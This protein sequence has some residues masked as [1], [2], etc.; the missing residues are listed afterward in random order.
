M[1]SSGGSVNQSLFSDQRAI[2][3]APHQRMI[4]YR[5]DLFLTEQDNKPN[6][7]SLLPIRQRDRINF[8]ARL[9]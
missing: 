7:V 5:I 3:I 9:A 2:R 6:P 8:H 4:G 1:R